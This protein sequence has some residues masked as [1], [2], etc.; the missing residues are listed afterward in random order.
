MNNIEKQKEEARNINGLVSH[1]IDLI[2]S[3]DERYS[4]E[5]AVGD[6]MEI[7]DKETDIGCVAHIEPI[8]YDVDGNA[9]N[10]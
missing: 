5:I 4:F 3:N 7:Y 2:E 10:L 8:K 6:M 9:T 1:L